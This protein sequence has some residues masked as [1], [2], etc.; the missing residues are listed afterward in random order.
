MQVVW[1]LYVCSADMVRVCY[2]TKSAGRV[3]LERLPR[4]CSRGQLYL[5]LQK[6][7][8]QSFERMRKGIKGTKRATGPAPI[9]RDTFDCIPHLSPKNVFSLI[10]YYISTLVYLDT[11]ILK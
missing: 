3:Q 9:K 6:W 11:I 4:S 7:P 1:R 5:F 2:T 10:T 8:A